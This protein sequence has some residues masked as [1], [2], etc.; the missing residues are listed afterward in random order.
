MKTTVCFGEIMARFSPPDHLRIAQAMPGA[1]E[2]A[3]AGAEANVAV[4]IAQLGGRADFVSVLPRNPVADAAVTALRAANVGVSK[5]VRSEA[6]RC[7]IY[8]VETG[9]NQRGGLVVYDR[10]GSAFA[11]AG[12]ADYSWPEILAEAGWFHTSGIAAGVSRVAAEAMHAAVS[13]ARRAGVTVSC[14]L[15]F[16]RK[17]WHWEPGVAPGILARRTLG[18]ILPDVDV[19]IGNP[20]DLAGVVGEEIDAASLESLAGPVA[21][22]ARV[23]AQFSHLRWIAMTLRQSQSASHNTWGALLFRPKDGAVFSAPN[24]GRVYAP[25]EIRTIVD[26]VG[27]GDVF[28]GALIFALQTADL[29][30]PSRALSFAVAASCLAHSIR[31]DFFHGTRVEIERM[32][33]GE[34]QGHVSR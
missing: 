13:A 15:N 33:D 27:T 18:A 10:E 28:A 31:G 4:T 1:M 21:L 7:G 8:F 30:D 16:R 2:V 34:D 11:V 19:L 25:Y 32:L 23:A 9:A 5:I 22:A 26:R 24:D 29:A 14:D 12:P 20:H 17:L 3:F 6:G